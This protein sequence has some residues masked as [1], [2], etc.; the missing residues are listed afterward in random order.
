MSTPPFL[1]LP[2]VAVARSLETPRGSFAVHDASPPA[3]TAVRGTALLVP[4]FTGS[5]EDFIA[6]LQPLAEA[7]YRVV[8]VDGRGQYESG[9]PRDE[10]A[11]ALHELALDVVAQARALDGDG[12]PVHLLGHSLGGLIGRAAVLRDASP[13]VSLT[14]L[15]SGPAAIHHEQQARTRLLLEAL[16]VYDQE[17]VWRA[18]RD[19]DAENG[20]RRDVPPEISDFLR[21]RWLA[22]VPEQLIA[23][24]R[25]LVSEPDRVDELAAVDLPKHV[26]SG[27]LDHAW[28]VPWMDEM[29]L[30]LGARRRVIDG[31]EHSPNVERP[32]ET[33]RALAGFWDEVA[34]EADR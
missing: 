32:A 2:K 9:G 5:K 8:A 18:M 19:L 21:T 1:T 22:T 3:G 29:A 30:R 17:T 16:S 34:R 11:Y 23:T 15:S 20:P 33:A 25:Q 14:I 13:F 12:F 27:A 4:G 31:A 10:S 6:L 28:P 24:G 7:G 26:V